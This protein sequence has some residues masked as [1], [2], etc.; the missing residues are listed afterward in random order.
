MGIGIGIDTGGTYTDAVAYDFD[1]CRVLASAKAQTTKSDLSVGIGNALDA[2]PPDLVRTAEMISLSTTLATNA[3]VEDKGG[4]ARLLFIGVQPW[5]VQRYGAEYGLPSDGEIFHLDARTTAAGEIERTPDWDAFLRGGGAWIRDACGAGIVDVDAM[6][7]GGALEKQARELL[8]SNWDIPVVC[9][10]ELFSDLNSLRRGSSVLLNARLV[11]LINEFLHATR[12]ALGRRSITAPVVI[13]RSDGTLMSERFAVQRPVE[14][15]VCGPAASV[16]GGIALAGE[17]DCL[18]IDMGGTT[19]D[20]AIVTG[21]VPRKAEEG[22]DVGKWKTFVKGLSVRSFGLG[23]DSAVRWDSHGIMTLEPARLLPLCVASAQWPSVKGK[24]T[25]LVHARPQGH[26]LLLHEL[27]CPLK[28]ISGSPAYS[29]EEKAFC[30]ALADG[31]LLFAEAAE[32][33]GKSPYNL[34]VHRLEEEG[35]ILRSGLTPTDIMHLRGDF[36]RFDAE[37][38][39][40]G[41][42]FVAASIGVDP[43]TLRQMVYDAVERKLYHAVV[44]VLLSDQHADLAGLDALIHRSWDMA[45]HGKGR[46]LLGFRFDTPAALVGIGAPVH[47]FLPAVAAALGTRCVIPENAGVANALGAIVGSIRV[48][49]R[50]EVKPQYS[51]EGID[52]YVVFGESGVVQARDQESAIRVA[53]Q[54]AREAATAEAVRRGAQGEVALSSAVH[55]SA[56]KTR[57]G[58]E[59]LVGIR[60]EATAIGK[61]AG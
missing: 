19:T 33:A 8:T 51:I 23:G 38:A 2:L 20:I 7:N 16:M 41:T 36:T 59:V 55:V 53:V 57:N 17:K 10:H 45:R 56:P 25:A 32:A 61:A 5:I 30:R 58:A 52:G 44:S 15:L 50:V 35:V 29:D 37:A 21:G 39:A 49:R 48:T 3:C 28:D 46:D 6:D 34:D 26:P 9:G 13:M 60:V 18:V 11:P 27:F 43:Q 14:T 1:S 24:L 47:L 12:T 4:R 31:P 42:E 40:L 22:V 54:A